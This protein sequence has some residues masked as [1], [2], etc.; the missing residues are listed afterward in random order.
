[1][2]FLKINAGKL[3]PAVRGRYNKKIK[4]SPVFV[5]KSIDTF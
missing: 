4:S 2:N 1:M 5:L 3:L